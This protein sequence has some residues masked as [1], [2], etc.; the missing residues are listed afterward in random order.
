MK[1]NKCIITAAGYGTRMLPVTKTITK[2]MLNIV[3]APAIFYQVKE[4]YLSG[5]KEIIF[6]VRKE[7]KPLIKN[8]FSHNNELLKIIKNDQKKLSLLK[9]LEEIIDN[10]K[11]HYVIEKEKGSYGAVYSAK[12][13]LNNEY[14]AVMF[15][16]DI[17]DS[18][19][20]LLK[21]IINEHEKTNNMIIASK[22]YNYDELP[23][24]GIIKCNKDNI[25]EYLQ[26]KKD[27][28]EQ[29]GNIVHGRF[30]LHTKLFDIKN[31]LIY[32]NNELQLPNAILL[33]KGEVSNYSY[34]GN[35][36][37]IGSKIGL[38]KANIYYGL[39]KDELNKDLK[40]FIKN[41]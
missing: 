6:V 40:D 20:P 9:E 4:A 24:Y 23:E 30:I 19:T 5:I 14:F 18:E 8:F 17:V 10:V 1:I 29:K 39:K 16:D 38:I 25:I 26:Y 3:D 13:L 31:K 22:T 27:I 36:F 41:I 35:Y 33:F 12:K 15:A 7:N 34:E 32:H 28:K 11:F 2:E 37:N 21:Q